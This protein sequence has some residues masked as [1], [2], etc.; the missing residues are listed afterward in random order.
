MERVTETQHPT[1]LAKGKVT[2]RAPVFLLTNTNDNQQTI[3]I[4]I[5]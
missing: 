5:L 2:V 3:I 1:R 4:T